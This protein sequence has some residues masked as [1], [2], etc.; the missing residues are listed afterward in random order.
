MKDEFK[1][2]RLRI[3]ELLRFVDSIFPVILFL[4]IHAISF[5][6]VSDRIR[7]RILQRGRTL[8][9]CPTARPEQSSAMSVRPV[10][11]TA[12]RHVV[13]R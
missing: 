9:R 1:V 2:D 12:V 8:P 10:R 3:I 13:Y 11:G 4:F 6:S 5:V 7:Q